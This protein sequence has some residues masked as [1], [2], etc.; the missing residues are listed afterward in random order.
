M[1]ISN[2]FTE[3][4]QIH[5]EKA[6]SSS[7]ESSEHIWRPRVHDDPDVCLDCFKVNRSHVT[8][9][10]GRTWV[11]EPCAQ[12]EIQRSGRRCPGCQT[13][14]CFEGPCRH[15]RARTE[16]RKTTLCKDCAEED[17]PDEEGLSLSN[18]GVVLVTGCKL[19]S[20]GVLCHG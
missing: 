16:C 15:I 18:K 12:K 17:I 8:C 13:F 3:R 11:C 2:R 7:R 1:S 10:C 14:D 9:P 19:L 4:A 5:L 6:T 20:C